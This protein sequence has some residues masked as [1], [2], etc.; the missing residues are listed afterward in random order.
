MWKRVFEIGR[1]DAI[2]SVSRQ[3]YMV[4]LSNATTLN[5]IDWHQRGHK[6]IPIKNLI[7]S[8]NQAIFRIEKPA[9]NSGSNKDF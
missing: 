4:V 3:M 9:L 2:N 1:S 7:I 5:F 6:E 8:V